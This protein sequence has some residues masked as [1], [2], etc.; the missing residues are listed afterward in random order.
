MSIREWLFGKN[1][2]VHT[3]LKV[4]MPK[5]KPCKPD[6]D[7]MVG[8]PVIS[9]IES[10]HRDKKR[11][12]LSFIGVD[13]CT[14][15]LYHWMNNAGHIELIDTKVGKTYQ[16]YVHNGRLYSVHN[17]PF[18]LNAWEMKAIQEAFMTHRSE[19]RARQSK[20]QSA[21]QTRIREAQWAQEKIDRLEYAKQFQ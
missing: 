10:L 8:E 4:P 6:Y 17:I 19:A 1:K 5:V 12:K 14:Y 21:G 20:I 16:A 11:Y 9:F 18:S 2:V 15:A 7:D 13:G 3:H